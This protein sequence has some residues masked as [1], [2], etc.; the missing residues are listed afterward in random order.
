MEVDRVFVICVRLVWLWWL[1]TD[2]K[3][4]IKDRIHFILRIRTRFF[5]FQP[6]NKYED[7]V[8]E[9]WLLER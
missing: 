2:L 9:T 8:L 5:W 1:K 4:P 7:T 6:L 3:V